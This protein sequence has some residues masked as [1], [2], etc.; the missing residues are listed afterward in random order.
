MTVG[1]SSSFGAGGGGEASVSQVFPFIVNFGLLAAFLYWVLGK[2]ITVYLKTRKETFENQ[3]KKAQDA[4]RLAQ[5]EK[6]ELEKK[7]ADFE[8]ESGKIITKAQQDAD[9]VQK[10]IAQEV[11]ILKNKLVQEAATAAQYE[12]EKARMGLTEEVY[13]AA[14]KL[15]LENLQK[16]LSSEDQKRLQR[17]S[18]ESIENL[19]TS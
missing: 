13:Q 12:F 17:Q 14:G 18:L 3:L 5:A 4:L 15:A 11:D 9:R 7:L 16:S 19:P 1:A 10:E 8:S 2:K 6:Q